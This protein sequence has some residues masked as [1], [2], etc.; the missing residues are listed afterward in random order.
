VPF[1]ETYFGTKTLSF[2]ISMTCSQKAGCPGCAHL[3]ANPRRADCAPFG[4]SAQTPYDPLRRWESFSRFFYHTR[5]SSLVRERSATDS[6]ALGHTHACT[7][8]QRAWDGE[9]LQTAA[10]NLGT[11]VSGCIYTSPGIQC[12]GHRNAELCRFPT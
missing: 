1:S 10:S 12:M 3:E 8:L 9:A 4:S 5:R 7:G 11:L 6:D 2:K